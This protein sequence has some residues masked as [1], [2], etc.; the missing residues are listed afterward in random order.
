MVYSTGGCVRT[1]SK[2]GA[3]WGLARRRWRA[4]R[5]RVRRDRAAL[6]LVVMLSLAV[7]EPLLCIIHCQVW[8][9]FALSS[10]FGAQHQ[11]NHHIHTQAPSAALVSAP[12]NAADPVRAQVTTPSMGCTIHM[13]SPS[14]SPLS[15]PPSPVHETLLALVLPIFIVLLAVAYLSASLT[16]PPR[17]FVPIPLRPPIP[18][19]G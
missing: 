15:A 19:A 17:V 3:A 5:G 14:G 4:W 7:F 12:A 11:H 16:G 18:I 9:P 13:G 6:A 1:V 10:Y 2:I 8:M